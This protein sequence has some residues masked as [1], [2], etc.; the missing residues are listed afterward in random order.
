[1]TTLTITHTPAAGTLLED[2]LK[3]DGTA[4]ILRDLG[5]RWSSRIT[6]WYVPRSRDHVPSRLLITRT[7]QLLTEAGFTVDVEIE[8]HEPEHLEQR[9]ADAAAADAARVDP[10]AVAHRIS[11]LETQQRK[12]HRLIYGYRNHL[13]TEFPTATGDRLIALK[14]ELATGEEDLA[15]WT[16]VRAQQVADGTVLALTREDVAAGDLIAY[17]GEWYPVLRVNAKSVSVQSSAG[18]SWTDTI[19]YQQISGHRRSRD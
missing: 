2:P 14:A 7:E 9:A 8:R 5:W 4:E 1:M 16:A 15:H 11:T 19:P 6:S 13:G 10:A 12:V 18:G 3:G 17:R